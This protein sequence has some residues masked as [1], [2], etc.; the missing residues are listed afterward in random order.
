MWL[1]AAGWLS[2]LAHC[3]V[4]TCMVLGFSVWYSVLLVSLHII[5]FLYSGLHGLYV[6]VH[7]LG[8]L[9]THGF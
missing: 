2:F 5:A 8:I 6:L 4:L 9:L 3:V 7:E 1:I